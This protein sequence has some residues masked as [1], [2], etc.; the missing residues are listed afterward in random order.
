M[1]QTPMA[2][3]VSGQAFVDDFVSVVTPSLGTVTAKVL[4]FYTRCML[5][6]VGRAF[7]RA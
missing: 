2:E 1:Y 4:R 7:A 3:V 5:S 6:M